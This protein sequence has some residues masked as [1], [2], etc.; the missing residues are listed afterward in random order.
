MAV[1]PRVSRFLGAQGFSCRDVISAEAIVL[2]LRTVVASVVSG[3]ARTV[4][5]VL[6]G[7]IEVEVPSWTC[8]TKA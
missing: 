7:E 2:S 6:E 4:A 3:F 8:S 1:L 5:K